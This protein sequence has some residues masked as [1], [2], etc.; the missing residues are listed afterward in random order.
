MR[1]FHGT[2]DDS[3]DALLAD[4]RLDATIAAERHIDGDAGFYLAEFAS[5]AS[6]FTAR[7]EANR[8]L[9]YDL[10]ASAVEA[11]RSASIGLVPIP[12]GR[13]PYFKG[14]ELFV[15]AEQFVLFNALVESGDIVVSEYEDD[16]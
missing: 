6:F 4:A 8:I 10:S 15:P 7:R 9:A 14:R 12:G 1:V 11:L 2:N 3:A 16:E 5:D 13:T